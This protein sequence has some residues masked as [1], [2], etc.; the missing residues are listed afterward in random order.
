[1]MSVLL[2]F[3]ALSAPVQQAAGGIT[4]VV[5]DEKGAVVPEARVTLVS[6]GSQRQELV[7]SGADGEFTLQPLPE[8]DYIVTVAKAGFAPLRL[9]K[10]SSSRASQRRFSPCSVQVTSG[11]SCF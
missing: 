1:M 8:G 6:Q 11:D 5:R 4:G 2:P 3:E 9:V 7:L 10:S